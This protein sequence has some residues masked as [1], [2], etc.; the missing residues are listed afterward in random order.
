[1]SWGSAVDP[2]CTTQ[3]L[4]ST[5]S[6]Q[7]RVLLQPPL[8]SFKVRTDAFDFAPEPAG[9]IHLPQVTKLMKKDVIL[10]VRRCLDEPPIQGNRPATRA[11]A[12]ARSLIAHRDALHP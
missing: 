9:M 12:P 3:R 1:M 6:E 10:D 4:R 8:G 7:R 11:R 2:V 5:S